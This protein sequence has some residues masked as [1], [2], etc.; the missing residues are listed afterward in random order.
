MRWKILIFVVGALVAAGAFAARIECIT[1]QSVE[2]VA[3]SDG[4]ATPSTCDLSRTAIRVKTG[5]TTADI[6]VYADTDAVDSPSTCS[7]GGVV[8]C[9]GWDGTGEIAVYKKCDHNSTWRQVPNT[10]N[11][12]AMFG[13]SI[14]RESDCH[15]ALRVVNDGSTNSGCF[16]LSVTGER[17]LPADA[18]VTEGDETGRWAVDR[19]DLETP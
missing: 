15:Y 9:N 1:G 19:S 13:W 3:C 16:Y 18:E 2:T 14:V 4:T 11:R 12:T 8:T 10:T 17:G 6:E 7:V 5:N